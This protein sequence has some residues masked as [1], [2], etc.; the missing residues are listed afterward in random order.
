MTC[1]GSVKIMR[2]FI[3]KS[4]HYRLRLVPFHGH[5]LYKVCLVRVASAVVWFVRF[6]PIC[7]IYSPVGSSTRLSAGI[8][9]Q[10]ASPR[11]LTNLSK[12]SKS[13]HYL[14][15]VRFVPI[16]KISVPWGTL[17]FSRLR[18][19]ELMSRQANKSYKS[20]QIFPNPTI[21]IIIYRVA[22]YWRRGVS[23]RGVIHHVPPVVAL[24]AASGSLSWRGVWLFV[25]VV[26]RNV[27]NRSPFADWKLC[28]EP[29]KA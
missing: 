17:L 5:G 16:C 12:S 15:F 2:F 26:I 29:I 6:V 8:L 19:D 10:S 3:T 9:L 24:A 14:L 18:R 25:S 1:C 7:R 23:R 20:E 27:M 28:F 4:H 13:Y 21:F 22:G 11:N